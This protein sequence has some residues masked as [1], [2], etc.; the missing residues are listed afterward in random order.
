MRGGGR[1]NVTVQQLN[2][3]SVA[4]FR[5]KDGDGDTV[6]LVN[7]DSFTNANIEE[8]SPYSVPAGSLILAGRAFLGDDPDRSSSQGE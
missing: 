2:S 3:V 6:A 4:S 5:I 1:G 7:A 8:E